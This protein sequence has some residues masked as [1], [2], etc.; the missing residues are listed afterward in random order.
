MIAEISRAGRAE[1]VFF[2]PEGAACLAALRRLVAEGWI[3]PD[4]TI[5]VFNTASGLKY[6]DVLPRGNSM[7]GK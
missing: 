2:C 5:L 3:T 6:L 7:R 1:G 4:E